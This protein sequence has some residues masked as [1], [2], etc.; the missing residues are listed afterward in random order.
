MSLHKTV[1][2]VTGGGQGTRKVL[3]EGTLQRIA[4]YFL[5][6]GI[7]V[8]IAEINQPFDR[9]PSHQIIGQMGCLTHHQKCLL[10]DGH[11][12]RPNYFYKRSNE[13][14]GKEAEIEFKLLSSI[15]FFQVDTSDED[16]VLKLFRE[17]TNNADGIDILLEISEN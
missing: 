6:K 15:Q 7:N 9:L 5:D 16:L 13:E 3:S 11:L 17:T 2:I 1:S 4:Q 10:W 14:A 12:A 8:A